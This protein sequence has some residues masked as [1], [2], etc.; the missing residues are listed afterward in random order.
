MY[1]AD[2]RTIVILEVEIEAYKGVGWYEEPVITM[3]AVD[4]RTRVTLQSEVEAYKNVGWYEEPVIIMYAADGRTRITLKSEIEAYKG[5]GWYTEPVKVASQAKIYLKSSAS[6]SEFLSFARKNYDKL[7]NIKML[8]GCGFYFEYDD[9]VFVYDKNAPNFE[10]WYLVVDDEASTLEDVADA[11]YSYFSKTSDPVYK[12][13]YREI[14][15][16]LYTA[17]RAMGFGS[18]MEDVINFNKVNRISN[19]RVVISGIEET[20]YTDYDFDVTYLWDTRNIKI[21]MVLE[22]GVWMCEEVR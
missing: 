12:E 6:D 2:G 5:V 9:T 16:R 21:T 20:Y 13:N 14:N 18:D 15:G 1:A 7:S 4:G 10:G 3:Y 17:R 11:W 19:K 22:N 8:F